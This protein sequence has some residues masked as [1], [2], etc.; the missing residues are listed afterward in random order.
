M[1]DR[2]SFFQDTRNIIKS[3]CRQYE[4]IKLYF[5]L[6]DVIKIA[7]K[8][9]YSSLA[10]YATFCQ[11]IQIPTIVRV[12]SGLPLSKKALNLFEA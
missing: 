4:K 6:C 1:K 2:N 9:F 7:I 5:S 10:L 11:I 12:V 3:S 8:S